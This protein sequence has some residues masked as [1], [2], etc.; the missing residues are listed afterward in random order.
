MSLQFRNCHKIIF[1][2]ICDNHEAQMMKSIFSNAIW[3]LKRILESTLTQLFLSPYDSYS[4]YNYITLLK[5]I[6]IYKAKMC[7]FGKKPD[8]GL[9]APEK[10]ILEQVSAFL[11]GW[12]GP[13]FPAGI[14][15]PFPYP[16]EELTLNTRRVRQPEVHSTNSN[17]SF[18][19]VCFHTGLLTFIIRK[20]T[21]PFPRLGCPSNNSALL[22]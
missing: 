2:V 18:P 4:W 16:S 5:R 6:R 11:H 20:S 12:K 1:S 17:P 7:H 9:K 14:H 8:L 22:P 3:N 21:N 13:S 15:L 19:L 10:R